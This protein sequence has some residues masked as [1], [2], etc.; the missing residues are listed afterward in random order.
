MLDHAGYGLELCGQLVSVADNRKIA[1][2]KMILLISQVRA[3][4][5]RFVHS[6]K[7]LAAKSFYLVHHPG[8]SERCDFHRN[9]SAAKLRHALG[10]IG[11]DQKVARRL[12]HHFLPQQCATGAFDQA[13]IRRDFVGAVD[14]QVNANSAQRLMDCNAEFLSPS[15]GVQRRSNGLDLQFGRSYSF[16]QKTQEMIRRRSGAET[17]QHVAAYVS[18]GSLRDRLLLFVKLFAG[19]G[20]SHDYKHILDD[21]RRS[22]EKA[23]ENPTDRR[24]RLRRLR[25]SELPAGTLQLARFLIGK[26]L[27]HDL[28]EGRISGRIVETEAYPP[29]DAAGHAFR[30][31]TPRNRSLFLR[32]GHAYVHFAY[33]VY[34]LLNVTSERPGIGAGVL[35]RGLELLEGIDLVQGQSRK[36]V[37]TC[38]LTRGPGLLAAAMRTDKRYDGA[39]LCAAGPLWLGTEAW[40]VKAIGKTVRIGISRDVDRR[41]R[42]YERGNPC[43]SGPARLLTQRIAGP[44]SKPPENH[45]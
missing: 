13:E 38:D 41:F 44:L 14:G 8:H 18:D 34:W 19:L 5:L 32:R 9:A 4:G 43:V 3:I 17:Q 11:D 2:E 36:A 10:R 31:E 33:G 23:W 39:D 12:S 45:R 40:P 28:P 26:T 21:V 30:G 1:V 42:F 35:L 7:R 20:G 15:R 16:G 22:S 25:R 37:R 29:G 24:F 27:V 6:Q